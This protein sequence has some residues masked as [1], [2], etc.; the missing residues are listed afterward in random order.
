MRSI[1]FALLF[2]LL[3]GASLAQDKPIYTDVL[4][5][6]GT[7]GGIAAA[8]QTAKMGANTVVVEHTQASRRLKGNIR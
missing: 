2:V 1:L 4:V 5:V 7:T 6:G 8:L 3:A